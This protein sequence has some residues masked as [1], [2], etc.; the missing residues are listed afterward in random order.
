MT[1]GNLTKSAGS[2]MSE[3]LTCYTLDFGCLFVEVV[4]PAI[5]WP[6]DTINVTVHT[7]ASASIHVDFI[8][9]NLSCLGGNFTKVPLLNTSST[10]ENVDLDL[11]FIN[12]TRYEI[13]IPNDT[14]PG[15]IFGFIWYD[16][17]IKGSVPDTHQVLPE[18][19]PATFIEDKAYIELKEGYDNLESSYTS[20]ASNYTDL[21]ERYQELENKGAEG[22][23]ATSLM[24]LFL[25]TTGIFVGTT[26]L[27]IVKQP[28]S[29]W[30]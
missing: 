5:A 16:W 29:S 1:I 21:Q 25:I 15:M 8:N 23:N 20:L 9:L 10:L 18:A 30:Q 19:F 28:K 7:Q 11:G 4:A 3:D 24:Y 2:E 12:E 14:L 27:L 13:I 26:I 17:Y 6:G 22:N